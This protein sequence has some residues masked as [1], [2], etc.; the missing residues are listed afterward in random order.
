MPE[1]TEQRGQDAAGNQDLPDTFQPPLAILEWQIPFYVDVLVQ[2]CDC[3]G[4]RLLIM[5]ESARY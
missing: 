4:P 3:D 2:D 1:E 5:A